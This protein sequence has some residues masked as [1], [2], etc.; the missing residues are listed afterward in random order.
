MQSEN[1]AC[2]KEVQRFVTRWLERY[3]EELH[4]PPR[5]GEELFYLVLI[6]RSSSATLK[7]MHRAN[8]F[9][10]LRLIFAS[11]VVLVHCH[12]LSLQPALGWIPRLFS[13][14]VAVVG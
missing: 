14:R 9:D 4:S 6:D 3:V 13:S 7:C 5:H 12:D 8:N 1:A 10:I 2:A 11:I